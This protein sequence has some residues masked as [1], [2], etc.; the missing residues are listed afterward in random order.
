M[1]ETLWRDGLAVFVLRCLAWPLQFASLYDWG[2]KA[3]GFGTRRVPVL[4]DLTAKADDWGRRTYGGPISYVAT[5]AYVLAFIILEASLAGIVLMR[6]PAPGWL[7]AIMTLAALRIIE[8]VWV[9]VR[10]YFVHALLRP[11][12]RNTV[13]SH[14]RSM[15]LAFLNYVDLVLCFGLIYAC[16]PENLSSHHAIDGFY[17]SAMTQLTVGYGDV[18]PLHWLRALAV[19]QATTGVIFG[20]LVFGRLVASLG[21]VEVERPADRQMAAE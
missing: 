4:Q 15:L 1:E 8:V 13:L 10:V 12:R 21:E 20:I 3:W 17:L 11:I 5:D 7:L 16:N 6:Q 14:H 2:R 9:L 18:A 19:V